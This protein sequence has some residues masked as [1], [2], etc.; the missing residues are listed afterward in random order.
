VIDAV[1]SRLHRSGKWRQQRGQHSPNL[2]RISSRQILSRHGGR[3]TVELINVSVGDD[4][5]FVYDT[6]EVA[7]TWQSGQ[8]RGPA[9]YAM[10]KMQWRKVPGATGRHGYHQRLATASGKLL[11]ISGEL[12]SQA[13]RRLVHG[14]NDFVAPQPGAGQPKSTPCPSSGLE[15]RTILCEQDTKHAGE[16]FKAG[17]VSI[18]ARPHRNELQPKTTRSA[19]RR[20]LDFGHNPRRANDIV[21]IRSGSAT[22]G[23]VLFFHQDIGQRDP[24][25]VLL[26]RPENLFPGNHDS[27]EG[28]VSF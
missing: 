18:S 20:T 27:G 5:A 24:Y 17:P 19:R 26:T 9:T 21:R 6:S 8:A 16:V 3:T 4:G 2:V 22:A 7:P 15:V 11:G 13:C 12:G 23:R 28:R 10:E 1:A 25:R 14:G